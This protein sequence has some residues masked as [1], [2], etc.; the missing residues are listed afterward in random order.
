[1]VT[2]TQLQTVRSALRDLADDT[3]AAHSSRF[4]K[5]GPGEYGEG[6]RF[7][8]IRVP[9]LRRLSKAHRDLDLAGITTLLTSDYHEER[10]LAV[11][12]LVLRFRN[13]GDTERR[14]IYRLYLDHARWIN[15]WDLVDASAEHILGGYLWNQD[16]RPLYRL[17]RSDLIWERR[18][19]VMGTFHFIK[20]H[21]FDDTL[22]I[23][24]LLVADPHDLI[25]K[26]VGW[27]LR[28]TGKRDPTALVTFLATHYRHM[29][30]TTLRYA[31]ERFPSNVRK[32]FLKGEFDMQDEEENT[33]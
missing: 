14:R 1:M 8:G 11:F 29:P 21:Q 10:M 32:S 31:I 30:R 33:E 27:M 2:T 17:A 5:T 7:L 22:H 3:I 25:H 19:A 15:S 9:P 26:A 13:T 18:M 16:R 4:F 24:G 12:I 20:R 28:E 23:A 6:D